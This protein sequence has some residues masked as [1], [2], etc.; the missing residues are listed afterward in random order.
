[1]RGKNRKKRKIVERPI[2]PDTIAVASRD[3]FCLILDIDRIMRAHDISSLQFISD[4]LSCKTEA[5]QIDHMVEALR[6]IQQKME[7]RGEMQQ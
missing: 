4:T 5:E 3:Q 6:T 1:M 2:T 7:S